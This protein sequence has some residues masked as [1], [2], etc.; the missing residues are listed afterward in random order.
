VNI[1]GEGNVVAGATLA[2]TGLV[3][4]TNANPALTWASSNV[5]VASVSA[6]GVVTGVA[7]GSVQI[8]ATATGTPSVTQLLSLLLLLILLESP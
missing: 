7:V 6:T 1:T 2:L 5:A 8:T 4:P 3:A